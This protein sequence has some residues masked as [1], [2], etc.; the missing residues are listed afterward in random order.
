[1]TYDVLGVYLVDFKNN[2]GGELSGKHY[3]VLL[4]GIS[5]DDTL[6]LI[7]I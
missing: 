6:S 3:A 2:Q 4:N 1:M 5:N 7:H